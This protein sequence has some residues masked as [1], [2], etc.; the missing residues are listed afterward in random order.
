[1]NNQIANIKDFQ[2]TTKKENESNMSNSNFITNLLIGVAI[3]KSEI[4]TIIAKVKPTVSYA[5]KPPANSEGSFKLIKEEKA[6]VQYTIY[7]KNEIDIGDETKSHFIAPYY[8]EISLGRTEEELVGGDTYNSLDKSFRK[9]NLR[10]PAFYIKDMMKKLELQNTSNSENNTGSDFTMTEEELE[11]YHRK[12][13]ELLSFICSKEFSDEVRKVSND[14]FSV[15]KK[16]KK[17]DSFMSVESFIEKL[18]ENDKD[19]NRFKGAMNTVIEDFI[20]TYV[21]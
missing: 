17:K 1:M 21:Y 8:S 2:E 12:T 14:E 5:A 9:P 16:D 4:G 18:E 10:K 6:I 13:E 11:K 7:L 15:K 20:T 3:P 19:V